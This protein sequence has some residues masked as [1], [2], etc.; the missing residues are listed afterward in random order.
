MSKV[1]SRKLR[2]DESGM[3]TIEA[4]PIIV[5]FVVVISY[6]L[7][8]FG[9]IHTGILQSIAART[10]A[11]DTFRHRTDLTY[12][13]DNRGGQ[14][15]AFNSIGARIHGIG[16]PETMD[17][18]S[19]GSFATERPILKGLTGPDQLGRDQNTHNSRVFTVAEGRRATVGVN[20]IWI[21]TQYG[22]CLN[23]ACGSP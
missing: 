2:N 21:M 13:R 7:G 8:F 23:A 3:A 14:A 16:T 12:L 1:P 17:F 18:S 6:S 4:L 11:Y 9:A 10:Y 15:F 19:I 20:P 22:M 5:V